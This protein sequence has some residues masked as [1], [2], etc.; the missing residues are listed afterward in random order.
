MIDTAM[1]LAAG[2]GERLQPLTNTLPQALIPVAGCSLL[3]RSIDRLIAHGVKNIVVNVHHLG[4]QIAD[5][6]SDRARIVHEERILETGGSV[7][8]ALPLLGKGPFYL[9]NGDSLWSDGSPPMLQRVEGQ[10]NPARM[11]ALLLLHPIHK[12]IGREPG[13]RGDYFNEPGGHLR[14]RGSAQLTP[15]VFAGVSVCDARLF[16]DSPDEPFSL[17]RLWHQAEAVK[18]LYGAVH[19]GDWS[20]VATPHALAAVERALASG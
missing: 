14:H 20:H 5:R 16:C 6:V 9:L 13:E 17:L 18:R 8:N 4:K 3:E 10:W 2:R 1:I 7:K 11:D 12:I 15:Y 19:D